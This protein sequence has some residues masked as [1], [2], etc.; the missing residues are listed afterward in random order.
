V[1]TAPAPTNAY[2]PTVCPHTTVALAPIDAPRRTSVRRY[3]C[4]RD[5]W[6]RGLSTLV[7]TIDGPQNTSSSSSTPSYRLT[8]FWIFALRPT[9]TPAITTTFWPSE[10]SSPTSHPGI[11]WQKCQTLVRAPT[12]AP[13]ST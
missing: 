8:L 13:A 12:R 2:A 9:R 7:N 6:L 3:S 10:Q 11:R 4:F 1:T 5:T